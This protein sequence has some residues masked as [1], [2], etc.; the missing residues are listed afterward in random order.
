MREI[1][2]SRPITGDVYRRQAQ[3]NGRNRA[4]VLGD[5]HLKVVARAVN[6]QHVTTHA[7]HERRIIGTHKAIGQCRSMGAAHGLECEDLRRLR[8]PITTTRGR[9]HNAI[10]INDLERV[11][12]RLTAHHAVDPRLAAQR[13]NSAVDNLGRNKRARRIVDSHVLVARGNGLDTG[14]CRI[15]LLYTSRQIHFSNA[16]QSLRPHAH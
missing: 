15:C 11:A 2:F 4:Q 14:A 5:R 3:E 16:W 1:S 13:T 12:C 8:S 9:L 6:A 7:F 10:T